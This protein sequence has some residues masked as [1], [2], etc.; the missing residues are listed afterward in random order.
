[1]IRTLVISLGLSPQVVTET[2][3]ALAVD[4]K[5]AWS[6]DE[7]VLITTL[8]GARVARATLL[9][10][11]DGRI[12]ALGQEYGREDL[13]RLAD[14]VRIELIGDD[15]AYYDDVDTERGHAAAADRTMRLIR[16]LTANGRRQIHASIAGGRKSQ[17]ALLALSMSL[18]ARPG[19]CLSHIVV[20]DA[21]LER[22]DF[23]FP[24]ARS[25]TF[26]GGVGERM[27]SV[28]ARVRLAQIPF[29]RIRV[30][31]SEETRTAE[32][33][34]DAILGVQRRLD[35]L[36]LSLIPA[37]REA[38]L[39]GVP[40]ELAPSLFAWLAALALDRSQ[41]GGGLPRTGLAGS[42][43]ERWRPTGPRLPDIVDA[44][45]VE[46]WT[47]R[48]NK[49]VKVDVPAMW[50]RKLIGTA[51]KRP[52]TRYRLTIEPENISWQDT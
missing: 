26:A 36:S 32:H 43:V 11:G 33:F 10:E 38:I 51:G 3:W 39:A 25:M 7:L 14:K 21:Y 40:L 47:S 16:D 20:D 5:P 23:F 8:Q 1:V 29:P 12:R 22:P 4:Q 49:L 46:E 48:L 19:D 28:E 18:F 17:G 41:G 9:D 45:M 13:A 44:E 24:P 27:N 30:L 37:R 15:E 34:A 42:T 2:L 52:N 50:G 31:L 6:P 35:P